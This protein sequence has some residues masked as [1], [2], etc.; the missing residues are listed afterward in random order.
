M[1][2]CRRVFVILGGLV[3]LGP[4]ALSADTDQATSPA[5]RVLDLDGLAVN[6]LRAT[7]ARLRV[8]FFVSTECPIANRYAPEVRRFCEQFTAQGVEFSLVYCDADTTPEA[9]RLHLKAYAYPCPAWR[10]PKQDLARLAHIRVTPECAV[11]HPDG[12]LLY[13][14]RIDNRHADFGQMRPAPTQRELQD[15][16]VAALAGRAPPCAH[17]PGVGCRLP[18]LP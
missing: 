12:Q 16:I 2:I 3:L 6:P 17:M 11:F 1:M 7:T 14:G 18:E 8:F 5:V 9:I 13:H 15:A 10:D 4:A